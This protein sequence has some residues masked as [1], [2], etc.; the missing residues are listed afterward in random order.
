M[1]SVLMSVYKGEKLTNFISSFES[2]INQTLKPNEII[3]IRDGEVYS[4]LQSKIDEYKIKYSEILTYIPLTENKGLGNALN[5]GVNVAKYDIIARM[6]TDD[7]AKLD[8]FEI[9]Y[10][11]MMENPTI[12][13]VGSNISEF[14]DDDKNIVSHRIVPYKHNDIVKYLKSRNPF[15]H[16]TVMFKKRAVIEAGNYK[17]LHYLEDYYLWC[18]MYLNGAKFANIEDVLVNARISEDMYRRRGGYKY[19]CSWKI[20]KKFMLKNKIISIWNYLYTL[21]Y[22]F[23]VQVLCPN[24]IRGFII[25]YFARK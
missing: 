21:F 12:D 11:F 18:R 2:I 8:R 7:V 14:I 25:K 3:L 4:E 10:G 24:K 13:V 5:L 16:M 1:F 9:Q 22:R 23:N 20:L 17:D 15:N 6:D 19:F